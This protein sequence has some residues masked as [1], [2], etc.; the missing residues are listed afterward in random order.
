[1]NT[2]G[3]EVTLLKWIQRYV[4]SQVGKVRTDSIREHRKLEMTSV[5]ERR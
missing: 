5:G 3:N 2:Q 1:M 4:Q